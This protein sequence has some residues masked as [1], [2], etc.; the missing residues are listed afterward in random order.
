MS[1]FNMATRVILAP[2]SSPVRTRPVYSF[3]PCLTPRNA[4]VSSPQATSEI[5]RFKTRDDV[6]I[7]AK[8]K[9]KEKESKFCGKGT[10][11]LISLY[12]NHLTLQG[13]K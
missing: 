4:N 2:R 8:R 7:I 9:R 11:N 12:D 3:G 13:N 5:H 6:K 1:H 10:E